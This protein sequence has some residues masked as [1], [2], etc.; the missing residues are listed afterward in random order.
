MIISDFKLSNTICWQLCLMFCLCCSLFIIPDALAATATDKD[1]I[2]GVLCAIVGKFNGPIGKATL[3]IIVIGVA[4][5][6]GKLN[7]GV[8]VA[9]A[10]GI[11]LIFGAGQMVSWI[12]G[13][14]GTG[15]TVDST[16]P[17][18]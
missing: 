4:L 17:T 16:C 10:I 8:A 3:A 12:G 5:F 13:A 14:G 11:G 1:A 15:G 18:V 2:S 6:L 9:T 7:W